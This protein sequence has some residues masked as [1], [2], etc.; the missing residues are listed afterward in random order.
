MSCWDQ[1][2]KIKD[3]TTNVYESERGQCSYNF[4]GPGVIQE[5]IK[6]VIYIRFW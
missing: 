6:V 3:M 2:K 1:I 5:E 4:W